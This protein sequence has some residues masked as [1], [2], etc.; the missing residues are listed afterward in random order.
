MCNT[1]QH[2]KKGLRNAKKEYNSTIKVCISINKKAQGNKKEL[3]KPIVTIAE[4]NNNY[5]KITIFQ[6]NYVLLARDMEMILRIFV[7]EQF[8]S[9]KFRGKVIGEGEILLVSKNNRVKSETE[10]ANDQIDVTFERNTK[11]RTYYTE[12][13]IN[14]NSIIIENEFSRYIHTLKKT[15]NNSTYTEIFNDN[16]ITYSISK[17]VRRIVINIIYT[18]KE[19]YYDNLKDMLNNEII[20]CIREICKRV[21]K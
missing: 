8:L 7:Y 13:L 21:H 3:Q 17:V 19:M 4:V 16:I 11:S 5:E 18:K 12:I 20:K 15:V 9:R 14:T 10:I 2:I 6:K 1:I